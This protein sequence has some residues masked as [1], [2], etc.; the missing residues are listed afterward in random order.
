M[1]LVILRLGTICKK[2]MILVK[3]I[4]PTNVVSRKIIKKF[5]I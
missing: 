5:L 2:D 4:Y 1:Q 3:N